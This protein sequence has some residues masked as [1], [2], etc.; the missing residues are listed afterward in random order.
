MVTQWLYSMVI[1]SFL[2]PEDELMVT[3]SELVI[4]D[5]CSGVTVSLGGSVA[6]AAVSADSEGLLL[7]SCS[8]WF[9][10][11]PLRQTFNTG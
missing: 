1:Q 10:G 8:Y 6:T 2:L 9:L 11:K 5:G 7:V 3:A 4:S